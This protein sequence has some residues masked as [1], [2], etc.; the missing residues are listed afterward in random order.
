MSTVFISHSSKDNVA[1]E[2]LRQRLADRGYASL[3]LDFDPAD[4]IPVGASWERTLYRQLQACDVVI[5]LYSA[6]HRDSNWCFAEIALARMG[7]KRVITLLIDPL[8]GQAI[9]S[10]L[11]EHQFLDLRGGADDATFAR[12]WRGLA[13][14]GISDEATRRWDPKRSPYPG[15]LAFSEAEA[16]VF[17]GRGDET[18]QIIELLNAN[19]RRDSQRMLMILGGSGSGKSSIVRAGVIPKLRHDTQW[20]VIDPFRPGREPVAE[21]AERLARA[22]GQPPDAGSALA[23]ELRRSSIPQVLLTLVRRT[24][25]PDATPLL[26]IDQFEELLSGADERAAEFLRMIDAACASDHFAVQMMVTLRSDFLAVLEQRRDVPNLQ[27]ASSSMSVPPMDRRALRALITEPA[28]L[29]ALELEDGLAD[30]LLEDTGTP[31][32][33]P[34][35]AFGLRVLW[36]RGHEDGRLTTAEYEALGGLGRVLAREAD[37]VLDA[38]KRDDPTAYALLPGAFVRMSRLGEGGGF[39]RAVSS[40]E[41]HPVAVRAAMRRFVD[42]RILMSRGENGVDRVEIAHEAL[43]RTWGPLAQWLDEQID[44]LRLVQFLRDSVGRF[45]RDGDEADLLRGPRLA[46]IKEL[47]QSG[48][49]VLTPDEQSLVER[50]ATAEKDRLL[51]EGNV[52]GAVL[53]DATLRSLLEPRLKPLIEELLAEQKT[54]EAS[55]AFGFY[56]LQARELADTVDAAKNIAQAQVRWHPR[57]AALTG[58]T[59]AR[60][61]YIDVFTFPCCGK[62][63][64]SDGSVS[65]FR[66]DGCQVHEPEGSATKGVSPAE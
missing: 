2:M 60:G 54:R 10:I 63:V 43:F 46:R 64:L 25:R 21:L 56:D 29:C 20:W 3:F 42:K 66:S 4:G 16:P 51:R 61:N 13:E 40:W 14:L 31:D 5:V 8:E 36:D 24:N 28:R 9:P 18:R 65:Q 12:L 48:Q 59:G 35:L 32:A 45:S 62:Q 38:V 33:L 55:S 26:V 57:E 15:M 52:I 22:F 6:H 37:A 27:R 49:I 34:L 23:N 19:K 17:F 53:A 50:S 41:D 58:N 47:A 30:R 39:A 7:G 11:G 44:V 1:A